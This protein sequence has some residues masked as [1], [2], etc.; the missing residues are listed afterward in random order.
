MENN[1]QEKKMSLREQAASAVGLTYL[2]CSTHKLA[3]SVFIRNGFGVNALD[4][5]GFFTFVVLLLLSTG[6]GGFRLY[7]LCWLVVLVA[8][9]VETFRLRLKGV[10]YHSR[11]PGY[12]YAA[13]FMPRVK[14]AQ[15]AYA[16]EPFMCL[17]AGAVL[18]TISQP[19]GLFVMAG[20]V[21]FA[22]CMGI[23]AMIDQRRMQSMFDAEVEMRY[24]AERFR[25][26]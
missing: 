3:I 12:P 24:Y 5:Q 8:R 11:Y 17:F 13:M 26:G 23:D 21:S 6:Y 15:D 19:V 20:F 25:K 18:V 14:T 1:Q 2:A 9:R 22:V 16:A 10:R 4:P 7:F